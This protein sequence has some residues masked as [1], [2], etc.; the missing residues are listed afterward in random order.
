MFKKFTLL[1][2]QRNR[3][4][5]MLREEGLEP[6]EFSWT[7]ETIAGSL[8]VSRLNFRDGTYYFQFS[9][10]E[11][12]AWCAVSPGQFRSLDYEYPKTWEEQEAIFKKWVHWLKREVAAPDLWGELAKYT[13]ALGVRVAE[14]G[15]NEP[16][17]AVEAERIGAALIRLA[18][19]IVRELKLGVDES[20]LVRSKLQYLA[21]AARRL[22]SADWVNTTIGVCASM[23]MS[24]YLPPEKTVALWQLFQSELGWIIQ[25]TGPESSHPAPAAGPDGRAVEPHKSK[26][27]PA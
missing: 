12:N 7:T 3:V 23:A 11:V 4:Y 18:A 6:S 8:T 14:E 27:R 19:A 13:L 1:R 25:L 15:P 10:H 24:L 16:I 2:S 22:R 5:E 26:S 9:S 21:E 17:S 20:T